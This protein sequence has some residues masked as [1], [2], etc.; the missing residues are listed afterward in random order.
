[1]GYLEPFK[2]TPTLEGNSDVQKTACLYFNTTQEFL[3][4]VRNL[5]TKKITLTNHNLL[6][7]CMR[8]KNNSLL[9]YTIGCLCEQENKKDQAVGF[10]KKALTHHDL[11][12]IFGLKRVCAGINFTKADVYGVSFTAVHGALSLMTNIHQDEGEIFAK[13]SGY[14]NDLGKTSTEFLRLAAKFGHEDAQG[15]MVKKDLSSSRDEYLYWMMQCAEWP[16]GSNTKE[17]FQYV[18]TCCK[19]SAERRKNSQNAALYLQRAREHPM[20]NDSFFYAG[21]GAAYENGWG[22]PVNNTEAAKWY[23]MAYEASP[24]KQDDFNSYLRILGKLEDYET[25]ISVLDTVQDM[26]DQLKFAFVYPLTRKVPTQRNLTKAVEILSQLA[27]QSHI[28]AACELITLDTEGII[29]NDTE[30]L[31]VYKS[32]LENIINEKCLTIKSQE[33]KEE[34]AKAY[35]CLHKLHSKAPNL[36][37]ED[38]LILSGK[39]LKFDPKNKQAQCNHAMALYSNRDYQKALNYY[40]PLQKENYPGLFNNIA[41]CYEGLYEQPQINPRAKKEYADKALK[42]YQKELEFGDSTTKGMAAYNIHCISR[43]NM[44]APFSNERLVE[45]LQIGVAGGSKYACCDLGLVYRTGDLGLEPNLA[46][47]EILLRQS[48]DMGCWEG[49]INLLQT[50]LCQYTS[51]AVNEVNQLCEDLWKDHPDELKEYLMKIIPGIE[52]ALNESEPGT[53][54]VEFHLSQK[55]KDETTENTPPQNGD[56]SPISEGFKDFDTREE[57]KSVQTQPII[58]HQQIVPTRSKQQRIE[59]EEK[60]RLQRKFERLMKRVENLSDKSQVKYRKI[61]TLMGQQI[62]CYSGAVKNSKGS[63]RRIQIH[64]I[65]TGYHQPHTSDMNG[66]ALNSMK[67]LMSNAQK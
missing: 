46:Q 55:E 12:A 17:H 64:D 13:L 8:Q 44:I 7:E 60:E 56:T 63:G 16:M 21:L 18:I 47:A 57:Q 29:L 36:F 49:K 37:F 4:I 48:S 1:M 27:S 59:Q 26:D 10:L 2:T 25:A 6:T 5:I 45:L 51:E 22:T 38:A 9:D 66:G 41:L 65:H 20:E 53:L 54:K 14:F 3:R 67:K 52:D 39:V 40:L 35:M 31:S 50:K 28:K 33:H 24:C 42:F 32:N 43:L 19:I 61:Q 58:Q 23:K 34:I 30:T 15:T 62:N 11:R